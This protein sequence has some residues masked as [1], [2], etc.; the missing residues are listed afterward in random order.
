MAVADPSSRERE[1]QTRGGGG[2]GWSE[3]DIIK[4]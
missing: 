4:F 1:R 2:G 3:Y